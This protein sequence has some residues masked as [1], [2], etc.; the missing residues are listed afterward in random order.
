MAMANEEAQKLRHEYIGTEHILLGLVK[1]GSGVGANVLKNLGVDLNKVRSEIQHLVKRGAGLPAT[2]KLPQTPRAKKVIEFAIEESRN[3]N[4]SY[5][6]TEHM[7]LGLLREQD[8]VAAQILTN[9]GLSLEKAREEIRMLLGLEPSPSSVC[10]AVGEDTGQLAGLSPAGADEGRADGLPFEEFFARDKA[11]MLLQSLME[12]LAFR[13][14]QAVQ[15]ANYERAA[16]YRDLAIDASRLLNRL[17]S[18]LSRRQ[19]PKDNT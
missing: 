14:S 11:A 4:F 6:G 7:L 12:E 13:A 1:E 17:A 2:G 15:D 19:P 8:G 18:I 3:F 5:V 10:G 16:A 9:R